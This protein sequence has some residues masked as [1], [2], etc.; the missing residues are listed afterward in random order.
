VQAD[1]VGVKEDGTLPRHWEEALEPNKK[2]GGGR[3][4]RN[5]VDADADASTSSSSTTSSSTAS[6][7]LSSRLASL[8]RRAATGRDSALFV[9][10]QAGRA[11]IL[12]RFY[13]R[14]REVNSLE[15]EVSALTDEGLRLEAAALRARALGDSSKNLKPEP[16]DA[17]LPRAFALVREASRRTLGLRPYDV[18]LVGAM[19]LHEG[20]V[21]E[22]KTGEGKTLVAVL[23]AFLNALTGKGVLIVTVNDYLAKRDREW[24]GK[25]LELLGLTTAFVP[26][27]LPHKK[28]SKPLSA[29]VC[30]MTPQ[31]LA[32]TYLHD[33]TTNLPGA[34]EVALRRPLHFAI[35]DEVDSVL[36]DECQ[37][38]MIISGGPLRG[39]EGKYE[40]A[41][42]IFVGKREF[43]WEL[44]K[45]EG[46]GGE[47]GWGGR[48][49]RK[50]QKQKKGETK[51]S[52]STSTSSSSSPTSST[53]SSSFDFFSELAFRE[54]PSDPVTGDILP[55]ALGDFVFDRRK[56]SVALTTAGAAKA[57][58]RLVDA[59]LLPTPSS[60]SSSDDGPSSHHHSPSDIELG[61]ALWQGEDPWGPY[62]NNA[63]KANTIFT[64][65]EQYIL[66]KGEAKIV[67]A[68]TG[69][70]L[71]ESRWTDGLHQ[72]VEA[73]EGLRVRGASATQ[74][75]I[76]FQ[77]LF[78][79][80]EKL[81][82][83]SG[84]AVSV[85]EELHDVYRLGVIPVPPHRPTRRVD[86]PASMFFEGLAKQAQIACLLA[87][88]RKRGR[89]VLLGTKSV[90]ESERLSRAL[91]S[92]LAAARLRFEK[93]YPW[94]VRGE[95]S[96]GEH[97]WEEREHVMENAFGKKMKVKGFRF[98][99]K[100]IPHRLLNAR[101]ELVEEEVR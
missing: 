71:P 99:P 32:F 30:W 31:Q 91:E 44:E 75:Q 29:D 92:G 49:V 39:D 10:K 22:M 54:A 68:E 88:A 14:V 93:D 28:R 45:G 78:R 94:C 56:R 18:Q 67:D 7:S 87:G 26:D 16:L 70:V 65:D 81:A 33:N 61:A 15:P 9:L 85:S 72:A 36:I 100:R 19:V 98:V 74:G 55:G 69:R 79:K 58:R 60:S 48:L 64:R 2:G 52:T 77:S 83:M 41:Q 24:V 12:R 76:T 90:A 73:K 57:A 62:V 42:Q 82:G 11:R 37:T 34:A 20:L 89:P 27:S 40:V 59:G 4:R 6:Q 1:P 23:A 97:E 53:S 35:V 50:E 51:L 96:M 38:P 63:L 25:P 46:G 21:A 101:P 66:R 3:E 84:T 86:H 13:S 17:L 80:F 95:V 43:T 47:E 8:F 5:A